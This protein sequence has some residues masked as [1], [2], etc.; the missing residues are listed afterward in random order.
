MDDQ[1]LLKKQRKKRLG[2]IKPKN[3]VDEPC[4]DELVDADPNNKEP[5]CLFDRRTEEGKIRRRKHN[6]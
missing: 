6:L 2:N 4:D 1:T 3:P 5:G